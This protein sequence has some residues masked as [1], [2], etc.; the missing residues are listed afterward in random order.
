MKKFWNW[1]KNEDTGQREL[2]LEGVIAEE[3]WW[4]DEVTPAIF[5]EELNAGSGV[6]V[7]HI[8]SPGGDCVAAREGLEPPTFALGK[9]CSILL[10]Y[11]ARPVG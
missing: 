10:S 7:L 3:S 2:W 6:I 11:R 5:K 8:N 9:R 4:G 1:I